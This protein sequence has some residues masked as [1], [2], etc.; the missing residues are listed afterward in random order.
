MRINEADLRRPRLRFGGSGHSELPIS[1][2]RPTGQLKAMTQK[3]H[4]FVTTLKASF[5]SE[6]LKSALSQSLKVKNV[7]K[8]RFSKFETF[9]TW[10]S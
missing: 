8:K 5:V 1:A 7:K 3:L 4:S 10:L 6:N 9:E 2:L